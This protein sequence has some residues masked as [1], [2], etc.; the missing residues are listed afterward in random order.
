[1]PL[2][3]IQ[4]LLIIISLLCYAALAVY[5]AV[6][7]LGIAPGLKN[8]LSNLYILPVAGVGLVVVV[9]F[10]LNIINYF[11]AWL[12]IG[13]IL[14]LIEVGVYFITTKIMIRK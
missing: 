4:G 11:S 12:I 7:L 13:F 9:N 1:L 6:Y 5:G 10:I 2:F 3:S 14:S 8:I